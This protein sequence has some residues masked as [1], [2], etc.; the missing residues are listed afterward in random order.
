MGVYLV[1]LALTLSLLVPLAFTF[2]LPLAFTL[3][4]PLALA[5]FQLSGGRVRVTVKKEKSKNQFFNKII[6]IIIIK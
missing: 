3:F 4:L 2:F 1:P 6:I 5:F